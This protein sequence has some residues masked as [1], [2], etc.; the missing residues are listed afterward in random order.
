VDPR[1]VIRY[2]EVSPDYTVRPDPSHT[3]EALKKVVG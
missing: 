2:S 3:V 1:R